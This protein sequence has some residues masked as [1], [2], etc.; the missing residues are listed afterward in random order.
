MIKKMLAV[1][2][3]AGT[4]LSAQAGLTT[5]S[6]P[7]PPTGSAGLENVLFNVQTSSDVMVAIGAH[8][9]KTSA[10]MANNGIDT[11]YGPSGIY[12]AD[13]KGYANWSFDFAWS[14]G[15][16]CTG[17]VVTL[18]VDKDPTAA[19]D[20]VSANLTALGSSY[21]E[22][23]NLMMSFI[24]FTFDPYGN[25]ITDFRLTVTSA[26][27]EP[28]V[29]TSIQVVVNADGGTVPEPATLALAGVALAGLGI[30]RRRRG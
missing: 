23:W 28:V 8:A 11:F 1:L 18:Y 19:N 10:S 3:L 2:T 16:S 6:S 12:A 17:C 5:L 30:A 21:A 25:S 4:V 9:Y 14:L 26:V 24:P 29:E 20:P 7:W 27:G 22:S 15:N 13:G